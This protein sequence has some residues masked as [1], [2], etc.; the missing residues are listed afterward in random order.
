MWCC[1]LLCFKP[2][3]IRLVWSLPALVVFVYSLSDSLFLI[4]F[5]LSFT[6]GGHVCSLIT[7]NDDVKGCLGYSARVCIHGAPLSMH[8]S[9]ERWWWSRNACYCSLGHWIILEMYRNEWV[10]ISK[11]ESLLTY[12]GRFY[13]LLAQWRFSLGFRGATFTIIFC[14]NTHT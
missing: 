4:S 12:G 10:Q 7:S 14:W 5:S 8:E 9:F 13:A 6:K 1:P 2:S 11:K 3:C